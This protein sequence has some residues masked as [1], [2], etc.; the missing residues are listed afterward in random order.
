ME[1]KYVIKIDNI[2]ALCH[3]FN[4]FETFE[5][6]LIPL[7]S[8]TKDKN[9]RLNLSEVS[10]GRPILAG[11]KA[12]NFYKENKK[13]IDTINKYLSIFSFINLNYDNQGKRNKNIQFLYAYLLNNKNHIK[14][15]INL[16]EKLK[17]LSFD[18]FI[19]NEKLD[20]NSETHNVSPKFNN[21][22]HIT[23]IANPIVIPSYTKQ[24][25]YKSNNS[26]YK[27]ELNIDSNKISLDDKKIILNS[28][29]FDINT[30]P[31][32]ID[33]DYIFD[34]LLKAKNEQDN[35]TSLIKNSVELNL[36][37]EDLEN[38]FEITQNIINNLNYIKNKKELIETLIKFKNILEILKSLGINYNNDIIK[39]NPSITKEILEKEKYSHNQK[40]H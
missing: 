17:E 31:K 34:P 16:L 12:K 37:I 35:L 2:L 40:K 29:V 11:K 30:L 6:K 5:K 23:Y 25:Y 21:N 13:A 14:H 18:K 28:L 15:I 33:K 24:I 7:I 27:I 3:I 20:F 32:K 19:F 26:N 9:F 22:T 8:D 36:T 38:Q 1:N 39:E 10:H 4:D